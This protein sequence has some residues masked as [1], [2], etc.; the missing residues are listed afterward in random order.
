ME[1]IKIKKVWVIAYDWAL[2][3]TEKSIH[4][5]FIPVKSEIVGFLIKDEPDYIAVALEYYSKD[6]EVRHCV[7]IP[8]ACIENIYE[9]MSK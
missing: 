4:D 1:Q 8:R 9:L 7:S 2:Y 5:D 6:N 3:G